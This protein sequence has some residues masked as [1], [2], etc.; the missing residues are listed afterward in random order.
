MYEYMWG[1]TAAQIELMT[2]DAPFIAYKK[3][4][5]SDEE[6]RKSYTREQARRDY[7]KWEQRKR[8]RKFNL[9]TFLGTGDMEKAAQDAGEQKENK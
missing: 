8:T 7:E 4:E 2:A 1:M 9:G 3:R 5:K 6:K